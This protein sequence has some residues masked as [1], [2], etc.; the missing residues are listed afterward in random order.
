[1]THPG[2]DTTRPAVARVIDVLL[3][4]RG[5]YAADRGEAGRFRQICPQSPTR[6]AATAIGA[7]GPDAG[8]SHAAAATGPSGSA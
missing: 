4:E 3:G 6:A 7:D 2:L 5:N 8:P 1:M